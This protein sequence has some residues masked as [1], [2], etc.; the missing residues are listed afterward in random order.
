LR[1]RRRPSGGKLTGIDGPPSYEK[2]KKSLKGDGGTGQFKSKKEEE[3]QRNDK[4][5]SVDEIE[6][7]LRSDEITDDQRGRRIGQGK[8]NERKEEQKDRQDKDKKETN[9]NRVQDSAAEYFA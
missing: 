8:G 4:Q 9:W 7:M 2:A 1:L 5:W 3:D 6:R